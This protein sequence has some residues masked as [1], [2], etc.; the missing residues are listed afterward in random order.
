MRL[1]EGLLCS[2]VA[3]ASQSS[4]VDKHWHLRRLHFVQLGLG[5][6]LEGLYLPWRLWWEKEVEVHLC[7]GGGGFVGDFVEEAPKGG[8]RSINCKAHFECA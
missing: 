2:I 4:E 7:A 6:R 3:R 1:N 5:D 8:N